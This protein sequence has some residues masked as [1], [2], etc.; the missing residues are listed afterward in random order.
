M[1]VE[2]EYEVYMNLNTVLKGALLDTGKWLR[3]IVE[4]K[5]ETVVTCMLSCL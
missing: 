2:I 4:I 1:I 3:S 5:E